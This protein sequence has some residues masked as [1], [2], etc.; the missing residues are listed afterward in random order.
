MLKIKLIIIFLFVFFYSINLLANKSTQITN[1][2]LDL[3]KESKVDYSKQSFCFEDY[4]KNIVGYRINDPVR[5]ASVTKWYLTYYALKTLGVEYRFKT[6]IVLDENKNLYLIGGNDPY[7]VSENL[8]QLIN[9][10][11][12]LGVTKINKVFFNKAFQFN[13][14][15][16]I[17]VRRTSLNKFFNTKKFKSFNKKVFSYVQ[18]NI[19][20]SNI[21]TTLRYPNIISNGV[22]HKEDIGNVEKNNNVKYFFEHYSDELF[23]ILKPMNNY[24]NNFIADSIFE[25]L[26]GEINFN[27]FIKN[28]FAYKYEYL[29]KKMYIS[30]LVLV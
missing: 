8:I 5:P 3:L 28:E 7:F 21:S 25:Y 10:L 23:K 18:K 9:K 2:I 27:E 29:T 19:D 12:D 13:W 6:K 26:G 22:F 30:L 17:K 20:E 24:S 16:N 11:E 14:R 15:K 1:S 4:K